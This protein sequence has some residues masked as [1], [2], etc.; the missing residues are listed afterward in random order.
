MT[1]EPRRCYECG[2][3]GSVIG[4][5]G[6]KKRCPKC[7]GSSALGRTPCPA[8][9]GIGCKR[10]QVKTAISLPAGLTNGRKLRLIQQGHASDVFGS[11]AGDLLLDVKVKEHPKFSLDE[12]TITSEVPITLSQAIL[13]ANITIETVDGPRNIKVEPGT[14]QDD[15]MVLKHFGSNE[16][17]P[18]DGYD[19]RTLRGDHVVK[20][21]IVMAE[22]FSEE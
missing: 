3:R 1:K 16:W 2:G 4:N 10:E 13:G 20:F 19:P 12:L 9:E 15:E 18:P 22:K 8:C 14:Q 6:I 7:D 21:K 17:N 5:Y 11:V